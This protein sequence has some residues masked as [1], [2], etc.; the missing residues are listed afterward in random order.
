MGAKV[1]IDSA[2]M[3]NKGLEVIEAHW[4]FGLDYDH[5][6]VVIH[7]ESIIHSY[8]EFVDHSV[9]A[10]LGMPDMRVPIQY[11]L[12]Y[13]DR[14]DHLPDALDLAQLG[15]L[16][17]PRD[18]F[19]ARYP[20][21]RMAYD[22]GRAGGTYPTVF[23]AANEMAVARFLEGRIRFSGYRRFDRKSAGTA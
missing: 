14:L 21:L 10:Q 18:G 5:I 15:R 17:F 3:A 16:A 20:C 22:S 4:L 6:D 13:P 1:T 8:V 9:M 12:T 23:N 19:E 11:A 7:P 2:T